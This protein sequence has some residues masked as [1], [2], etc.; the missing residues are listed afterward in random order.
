MYLCGA[1]HTNM[2]QLRIKEIMK[3]RGLTQTDLAKRLQTS[4]PALS[5]RIANLQKD[6]FLSQ[7]ADALGVSIQEL[8]ES[9]SNNIKC[10]Y[11]GH[12]LKIKIE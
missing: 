1:K 10:P 12:E 3:E 8:F 7:L 9:T 4:Q 6:E 11:C 5:Q 2:A